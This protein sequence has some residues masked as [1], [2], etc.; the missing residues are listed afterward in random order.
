MRK[1]ILIKAFF[2]SILLHGQT[3]IN[4]TIIDSDN[5][6]TLSFVNSGIKNKNIGTISSDLGAFSILIP[7]KYLNDTLT[8]SLIGYNEL[9]IPIQQIIAAKPQ[10]FPLKI[11]AIHLNQVDITV[12]K[13]KENKYGIKKTDPKLHFVD[14]SINQNDISEIAQ[15]ITLKPHASKLSSVNLLINEDSKDSVTIRINFYGFDG[16][17]PTKR[18]SEINITEKRLLKEG[19]VKFDVKRYDIYLKGKVTVAIEF[20]PTKKN[21]TIHYEVKIGGTSRSFVRSSSLGEWNTPPHHYRLFVTTLESDAH[22][23]PD[24]DTEE[25][26]TIPTT[27]LFSKNVNDTFSLFIDLP[28]DYAKYKGKTYPTLFLLDANFYFDIINTSIKRIDQANKLTEP[29][30]IGIGYKNFMENDSL[31]D[32]DYSYPKALAE[33]SFLVSG[34]AHQFLAFIEKELI[35]YIDKNFRTDT[36]NRTL[37]GHSLGGYFSLFALQ[38]NQQEKTAAFKNYVA[39]SPSLDYHNQFLL[40]QFKNIPASS[41]D[42]NKPT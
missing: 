19:W 13:L 28:K 4:G 15:V 24:T 6:S 3:Q 26:E 20:I 22:N 27:R 36:S 23:K 9:S 29:I 21:N 42:K 5:R 18:L 2:F 12:S 33:D 31:R 35:P 40:S 41:S 37:M 1:I 30:V 7:E 16:N 14:A 32:R 11:K 39:A 25:E 34:G 8:F 17:R 10:V 38:Q